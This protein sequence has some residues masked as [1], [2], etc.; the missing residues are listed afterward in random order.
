MIATN[1]SGEL[2]ARIS[3]ANQGLLKPG[4]DAM[5]FIRPEA[6]SLA[7]SQ[8]DGNTRVTARVTNEEFEGS[9]FNIFMEG[10]Q[11]KQIKVAIPNLGQSFE[12]RQGLTIALEYDVQNAVAMPAGPMATE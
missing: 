9:A 5:M 8:S 12:S 4:D 3:P 11:G 2:V 6:F 1:R 7:E 10:D